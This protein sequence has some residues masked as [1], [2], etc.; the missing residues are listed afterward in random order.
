VNFLEC[1][2]FTPT[3]VG[4]SCRFCGRG[5]TG[6]E[7]AAAKLPAS[8]N[9]SLPLQPIDSMWDLN[10]YPAEQACARSTCSTIAAASQPN[11]N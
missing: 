7:K 11:R 8:L 5:V 10:L 4:A 9:A 6:T 2:R 3:P 1:G